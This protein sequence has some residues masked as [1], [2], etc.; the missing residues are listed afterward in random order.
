MAAKNLTIWIPVILLLCI[1]LL[2][3]Y[4]STD[5]TEKEYF[6]KQLFWVI[7]CFG[8]FWILKKVKIE[9]YLI[10][11]K[12]LYAFGIIILTLVLIIGKRVH[13]SKSW[14]DFSYF[15]F[16][17]SELYKIVFILSSIKFL[18][19]DIKNFNLFKIAIKFILFI[20]LPMFLIYCQPD[21]G[22]VLVFLLI[23]FS[24]VYVN[25]L[26]NRFAVIIISF[27][28]LTLLNIF[29]LVIQSYN[30]IPK[31]NIIQIV[32]NNL[33]TIKFYFIFFIVLTI[34]FLLNK[35]FRKISFKKFFQF[36]IIFSIIFF[37]AMAA[38]KLTF[39][40][41]KYY[42][43]QRIIVF[44]NPFTDPLGYGYNSIQSLIAIGSGGICG[45]GLFE[46]T[47]SRLGF[48]PEKRTDFIFSVICE[49]LG[50][51]GA[52]IILILFF[53][54]LLSMLINIYNVKNKIYKFIG[55]GIFF[56]TFY[57]FAINV[58]VALSLIPVIGLPL[59]LI[60]Y[61]GSSLLKYTV[62]YSIVYNIIMPELEKK[63][64]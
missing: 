64:I 38:A 14:L 17:P 1:G 8:I 61:G 20:I 40:H 59:P 26:T 46:G 35:I 4:S 10:Y 53:I 29:K 48:L 28:I 39:K 23:F 11:L 37:G 50:F 42:Q 31:N 2:M 6:V 15:A 27:L 63:F 47:Q 60:S 24:L 44:L 33:I 13:G 41:L 19:I 34:F 56:M 54:F 9:Y 43:V 55:L 7:I 18:I 32:V 21:T 5:K 25:Y 16:Q 45:K 52:S 36:L 49:E 62:S 51:I 3:V 30:I 12:Y 57:E 22:T 58:A